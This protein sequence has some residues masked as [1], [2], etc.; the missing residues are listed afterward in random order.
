MGRV[1]DRTLAWNGPLVTSLGLAMALSAGLLLIR[2]TPLGGVLFILLAVGGVA[3]VAEP[4]VGLIIMLFLGPLWAYLRAELVQVPAQISQ[5][6]LVLTLGVWVARGLAWRDLQLPWPLGGKVGH[7][8][9]PQ[10]LPL[11]LPLLV[12]LGAALLSLWD[13]VELP[14]Y[15]LP[16]M[17]KW[18]QVFLLFLFVATS[19]T[20]RK[21]GWLVGGL[22]AIGTFQACVGMW[23][24]GLRGDGPDHFAILDERFYRAYGTFEQPNPYAGF[25]G[26]ILPLAVGVVVGVV[27]DRLRNRQGDKE[28]GHPLVSL[29]SFLQVI[30][31]PGVLVP[32]GVAVALG[33]GLLMSWSRGGW[34]GFGAASVVMALALPRKAHWGI[35]VVAVL[36]VGALGL[37]TAGLMPASIS[38]RLTGF[39]K[40]VQFED[41]R[42]VGINDANFAVIERLAHWQAAME[43][44]RYNFWTGV[45]FGCYEP[46]YRE[47]GLI[48][49]RIPLGHAHNYYLNIAAET[50][51]IGLAAYLVLWGGVLWQ[52]WRVTRHADGL[53]RGIAIGLLGTWTHL[54]V[55]SGFDNLYVNN[56]HLYIGVLLGLLAFIVK[57]VS[58]SADE[59]T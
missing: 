35:L 32:V 7:S 41:V 2:L 14:V 53:L 10:Q 4:L 3:T 56:V 6:F 27:G 11:Q 42:G 29:S 21:L 54:G 8:H 30:L 48:N 38:A 49:W 50:G 52:T 24:F 18:V 9:F 22:L 13:A 55:H 39:A 58:E 16:E 34:L 43:M 5:V 12:F 33:A 25:L 44:W 20:S 46:A 26:L 51:V 19:L 17:I 23:Q 37:Q 1:L 31:T 59:Q 15:G 47:F 40:Y 45:G 36:T 28:T 57:R